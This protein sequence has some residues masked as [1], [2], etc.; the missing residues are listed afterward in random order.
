MRDTDGART[1]CAR[2]SAGSGKL[3]SQGR[4]RVSPD[5]PC[6]QSR[7]EEAGGPGGCCVSWKEEGRAGWAWGACVP[8]LL[9]II[10]LSAAAVV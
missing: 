3:R 1:G 4:A 9:L 8:E 6:M 10:C 7:L 5:R 2:R